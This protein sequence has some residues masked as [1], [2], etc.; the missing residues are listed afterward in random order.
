MKV[1][2]DSDLQNKTCTLK[3]VIW[4]QTVVGLFHLE[5]NLKKWESDTGSSAHHDL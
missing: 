4:V 1:A 3:G 5:E 2:R